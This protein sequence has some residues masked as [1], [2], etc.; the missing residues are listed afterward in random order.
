MISSLGYGFLWNNPAVGR[1][2][3]GRN[4]TTWEA[5]SSKKIDYWVTAGDTPAEIEENYA[6]VTGTG[7]NAGIWA[8]VL[9]EQI[10]L[11]HPGGAA[12][13]GTGV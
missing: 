1:V 3:F 11:L 5:E 13:S 9:A 10:A 6:S 12:G 8:G 7:P 4:K 2:V